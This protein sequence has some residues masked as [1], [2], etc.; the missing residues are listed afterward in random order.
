MRSFKSTKEMEAW[1]EECRAHEISIINAL[2]VALEETGAELTID[3]GY[4]A[5][6]ESL[7]ADFPNGHSYLITDGRVTTASQLRN[8]IQDLCS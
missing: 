1:E 5:G 6:D 4:E 7:W 3:P 8:Q 2:L